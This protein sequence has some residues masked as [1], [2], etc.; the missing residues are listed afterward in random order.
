MLRKLDDNS[1]LAKMVF[2]K[3]DDIPNSDIKDFM[4]VL[5]TGGDIPMQEQFDIFISIWR[6][7]RSVWSAKQR[8]RTASGTQRQVD[9]SPCGKTPR[10]SMERSSETEK[11]NENNNN[12][13]IND[14]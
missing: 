3:G 4:E 9:P 7:I 13:K 11:K 10:R 12:N 5:S 14:K 6:R 1:H 2:D 8:R